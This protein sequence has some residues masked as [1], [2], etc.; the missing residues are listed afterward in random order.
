MST[1]QNIAIL[2][3]TGSIGASTLDVIARHPSRFRVAALTA[4]RQVDELAELCRRHRPDAV[5]VADASQAPRLRERLAAAGAACRVLAGDE[6]LVEIASLPGVDCVMA[7][8]VGAA[9]LR[10]TLAAA[11]AGKKLLLANKEALVVAGPVFMEAVRA[12]RAVL[13]PIDSEHNAIFQCLPPFASGDLAAKGIRRIL[14]TGSGGPFRARARNE[15]LRVTP[16]EACAHPNWVMGRKISVDSATMMNKGL[17]VIEAHWLFGAAPEQ[18]QV[19]VHPQ[20]VVH[21]MVEFADGSVIA[22][23]GHP[24]M[25]TPIAQALAYPDRV[26]AGVPPLD[27][28]GI[29]SLGF[30]RPDFARFPA[31]G[32]AYAALNSGGSAPATLNAANEVAVA[33]FLEGRLPFLQ[34]TAV[35]EETLSALDSV[36]ART[37]EEVLEADARARMRAVKIVGRFGSH[38]A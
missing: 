2:G 38:A 21:S 9:G 22:Q 34:I 31:L 7:A 26:D 20:S 19:V 16:D 32:L 28:F 14:L 37:L 33:A 6:G 4:N 3:A 30:E 18:I 23:L 1:I 13:L 17:E 10:A 29:G 24:D 27:L 11:R 25:R 12:S 36:P 35:I 5:C 15:L 8:I